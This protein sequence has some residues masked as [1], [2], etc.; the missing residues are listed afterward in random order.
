MNWN[1][2]TT[3]LEHSAKY[4]AATQSMAQNNAMCSRW[5]ILRGKLPSWL[6]HTSIYRLIYIAW[7]SFVHTT[8]LSATINTQDA[9]YWTLTLIVARF[10]GIFLI[11]LP[12]IIT[13]WLRLLCRMSWFTAIKYSSYVIQVYELIKKLVVHSIVLPNW[14]VQDGST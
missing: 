5:A 11:F 14:T 12:A 3:V 7:Q 13:R 1:S 4:N 2:C 6:A 8:V 9:K 10:A